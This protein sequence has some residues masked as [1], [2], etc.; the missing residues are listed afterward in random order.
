[1]K[2]MKNQKTYSKQYSDEYKMR[3]KQ[4]KTSSFKLENQSNKKPNLNQT[5]KIVITGGPCNGKTTCNF[6][7]F[8]ELFK[9]ALLISVKNY[10]IEGLSAIQYQ[11]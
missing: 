2:T 11:R 7:S 10:W 4:R 3:V 6:M 8:C 9:K 5:T 1:M